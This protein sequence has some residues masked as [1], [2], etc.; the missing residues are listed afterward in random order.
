[1]SLVVVPARVGTDEWRSSS[2]SSALWSAHL[3]EQDG[4]NVR[5]DSACTGNADSL[6][7]HGA[8]V[9]PGNLFTCL[10]GAFVM[11]I[12]GITN[13]HSVAL[14]HEYIL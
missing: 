6:Q 3:R 1:M 11:E 14:L 13:Q 4:D 10:E 7:H 2:K 5:V 9:P 8:T 12:L